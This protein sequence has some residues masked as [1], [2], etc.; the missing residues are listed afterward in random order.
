MK[1]MKHEKK[2]ET[3]E[4]LFKKLDEQDK[5]RVKIKL[6]RVTEAILETNP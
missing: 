2:D 1:N 5:D 6:I 3:L 4:N